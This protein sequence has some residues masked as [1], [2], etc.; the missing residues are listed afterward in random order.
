VKRANY[1]F[2]QVFHGRNRPVKQSMIDGDNHRA[3]IPHQS[4]KTKLSAIENRTKN[5]LVKTSGDFFLV[6]WH[7]GCGAWMVVVAS[8]SATLIQ[9]CP[10]LIIPN[11]WYQ[12]EFQV[13]NK[14]T[15]GSIDSTCCL[16]VDTLYQSVHI[17]A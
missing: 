2:R 17:V 12:C 3:T 7:C 8:F 5:P 13:S 11:T 6:Q 10:V 9:R 16:R 1:G 4:L 14:W 15:R